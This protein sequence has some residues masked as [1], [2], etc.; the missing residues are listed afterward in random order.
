MIPAVSSDLWSPDGDVGEEREKQILLNSPE[1]FFGREL[2]SA[3]GENLDCLK[4][5]EEEEICRLLK[6]H[7]S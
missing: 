4:T 1:K 2:N 7:S 3:E 6:S 5:K